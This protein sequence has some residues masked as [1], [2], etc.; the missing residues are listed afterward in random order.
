MYL[1]GKGKKTCIF[2]TNNSEMGSKCELIW[3][4]VDLGVKESAKDMKAV[5]Q[6]LKGVIVDGNSSRV[7][8]VGWLVCLVH[9]QKGFLKEAQSF[10][11][12]LRAVNVPRQWMALETSLRDLSYMDAGQVELVPIQCESCFEPIWAGGAFDWC[13]I[14]KETLCH[15]KTFREGGNFLKS[16]KNLSWFSVSGEKQNR[17]RHKDMCISLCTRYSCCLAV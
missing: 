7:L 6:N 1:E 4:D 15:R 2:G 10:E 8:M 14:C 5:L 13:I 16:S 11:M 12:H 17:N 9:S 3:D